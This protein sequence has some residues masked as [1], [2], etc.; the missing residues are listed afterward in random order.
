MARSYIDKLEK[1]MI[2]KRDQRKFFKEMARLLCELLIEDSKEVTAILVDT[3]IIE[4]SV[5][6]LAKNSYPDMSVVK[7]IVD[8]S[9]GMLGIKTVNKDVQD[10]FQRALEQIENS[11]NM[12]KVLRVPIDEDKL[13]YSKTLFNQELISKMSCSTI[14]V[15]ELDKKKL[16]V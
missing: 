15:Y 6:Y 4:C 7:K 5:R 10:K 9:I 8:F 13:T 2:E 16:E 3:R 14:L 11:S 1:N 12:F